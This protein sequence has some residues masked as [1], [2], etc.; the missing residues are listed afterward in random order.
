[1]RYDHSGTRWRHQR[2]IRTHLVIT[3]W[4]SAARHLVV[5]I[6]RQTMTLREAMADL[7]NVAMEELVRQRRELPPFGVLWRTARRIQTRHQYALYRQV[8]TRLRFHARPL[9]RIS[10]RVTD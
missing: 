1:M 4:D 9:S 3:P 2:D 8:A 6:M 7:V 10:S 5:T